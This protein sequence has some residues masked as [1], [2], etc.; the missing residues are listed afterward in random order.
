MVSTQAAAEPGLYGG[1]PADEYHAAPG[2]SQ[3]RL[4]VL[5]DKSPAHLKW[6]MDHPPEPTPAKRLG[7][8]IHDAVLLPDVFRRK[9]KR[10]PA[11]DKRTK[12]GKAMWI[13]FEAEHP[14]AQVLKPDEYDTVLGVSHAVRAHPQAREL[15]TGDAEQSA[16][17]MDPETGVLCKGRFD[18]VGPP[19]IVDLKTTRDASPRVFEKDIY[20]LGYY[21]QGGWYLTGARELGLDVREFVFI[22]VEK[23]PPYGVAMYRL[24]DDAI[25]AGQ[26]EL[27]PLLKWYAQCERLGHYP[28]FPDDIQEIG[29]PAWSWNQIAERAAA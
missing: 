22:A 4:K 19:R 11:V 14:N 25:R 9:W 16:W 23:V 15:L 29:L 8:A 17:W 27:R 20:T 7:T 13:A 26:E 6:E 12:A 5:R 24:S 3:G 1:I 18:V 28:G 10:A 2:A 21:L